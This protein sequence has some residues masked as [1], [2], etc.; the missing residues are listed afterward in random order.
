MKIHSFAVLTAV[1]L[2]LF[3]G[4]MILSGCYTPLLKA[5]LT[6][7]P[8]EIF[9]LLAK[10]RNLEIRSANPEGRQLIIAILESRRTDA[11]RLVESGADVNATITKSESNMFNDQPALTLAAWA[12]D[13][14]LVK[15]LSAKGV[16]VTNHSTDTSAIYKTKNISIIKLLLDSGF[17][18]D[19]ADESR[20]T[21]LSLFAMRNNIEAVRLLLAR[22]ADVEKSRSILNQNIQSMGSGGG[23]V[24]ENFIREN[25]SAI[26]LLDRLSKP[27]VAPQ[28][29]AT[30]GVTKDELK[31]MMKEAAAETRQAPATAA[32]VYKSDVDAPV[33]KASENPDAYA[34]VV[35]VEKYNALPD[36]RFAERD[37]K[38]MNAH[39]L[40]MG[41]P[42]R[43]IVLLTGANATKTGLIKNLE[44]WLPNQ[45]T[46]RSTV[47]FY[48]SGHGAPDAKTSAAYLVP[49]DGD[50]QYLEETAYPIKRLYEK[51]GA[52]KA[53]RVLV[54][55][56]SCFSGAGG[57]SVIAS[58]TRPLVAKLKLAPT[59]AKV[60]SL[61]ASSSEEITGALE[62][63]GHGL[64]TYHLLKALSETAGRGSVSELHAALTPRVQDEARRQNRS[65]TPQMFGASVDGGLR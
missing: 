14:D 7:N 52:L 10:D 49:T 30:G 41:Y 11:L 3:S 65:Q 48:F 43:N 39:L 5:A 46:E 26:Q 35:G 37:A 24:A 29:A 56:D 9:P 21:P 36:A 60:V 19:G 62:D 27:Q 31:Q 2:A 40:A 54:A 42:Q 20:F 38:A 16:T 32:V 34:V 23:Q 28:A 22:G 53:K 17:P 4:S 44:A 6:N 1:L 58:G 15:A 45:V 50:P 13:L 12:D 18:V 59:E 25:N 8:E 51:L 61:S 33:Y 55:L 57:R 63:Q 64:F 47:M